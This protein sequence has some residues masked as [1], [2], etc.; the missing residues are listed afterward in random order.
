M[1]KQLYTLLATI[2]CVGATVSVSAQKS[3][4]LDNIMGNVGTEANLI[5]K[6]YKY[7]GL[8][9]D[10]GYNITNKF[11]AFLSAGVP[12]SLFENKEGQK[13]YYLNN[14]YGLGAGYKLFKG[15]IDVIDLRL[16]GGSTFGKEDWK[17]DYA[18][19]V[20]SWSIGSGRNR[21]M[22]GL[23]VKHHFSRNPLFK[24]YTRA[25][26]VFGYSFGL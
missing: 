23:G 13:D 3:S 8:D 11:F 18:E 9:F 1:R 6:E 15:K 14:D 12:V 21:F 20:V 5:S 19:A 24:G 10:L 22:M 2:I 16:K 26:G 7:T 4:F 17:Y 25:F